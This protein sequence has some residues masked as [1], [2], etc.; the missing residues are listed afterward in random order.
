MT[1]RT[2]P[3][4]SL[5]GQGQGLTSL[6]DMS[7]VADVTNHEAPPRHGHGSIFINPSQ[8]IKF[9]DTQPNPLHVVSR[10]N[11]THQTR[12]IMTKIYISLVLIQAS[13]RH[14]IQ[15]TATVM[16]ERLVT[17]EQE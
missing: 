2:K 16:Y 3:G 17:N 9:I 8:P 5:R 4:T 14:K 11:P 13:L 12:V 1:L 7:D 15:L 6:V 10:P